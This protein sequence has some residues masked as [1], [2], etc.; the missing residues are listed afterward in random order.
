MREEDIF[1]DTIKEGRDKYFVEYKPANKA[2]LYALVLL[3]FPEKTLVEDV[4]QSMDS[5]LHHWLERFPVPVMVMSFGATTDMLSLRPISSHDYLIGWRDCAADEIYKLWGP[6]EQMKL[7]AVQFA[8]DHLQKVYKEIPFRIKSEVREKN[9]RQA[10]SRG[11][12]ALAV[13]FFL[14]VVPVLVEIISLCDNRVDW[15]VS[16]LSILFGLWKAG[17]AFGWIPQSKGDCEKAKKKSLMEHYF[18]HCER[19]PDAFQRLKFENFD[20]DEIENTRKEAAIL[21]PL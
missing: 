7:P 10:R 21:R 14:F 18:W 13:L 17:K 6:I 5:E 15:I 8:D 9:R 3:T 1:R 20:R 16:G 11:R 19:N 4:I 2:T 12:A